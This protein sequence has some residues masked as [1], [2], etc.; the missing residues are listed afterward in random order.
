MNQMNRMNNLMM[1]NNNMMNLMMNQMNRMNNPMMQNNNMMNQMNRNNMMP[2]NN[3]MNITPMNGMNNPMMQNTPGMMN[4]N[5][6][7]QNNNMNPM[8]QNNNMNPMM[9]NSNMNPMM[10]QMMNMMKNNFKNNQM[11]N[12]YQ[13]SQPMPSSKQTINVR[14]KYNIR[15]LSNDINIECYPDET[16]GELIQKYRVKTGDNDRTKKFIYNAKK[17]DES[18][19]I[20]EAG[21]LDTANIFVVKTE[22][23][24]GA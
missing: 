16:V 18:L 5:P 15:N 20:S 11:N 24:M 4:R 6:M 9:P 22:G 17:L 2:N 12:V 7:M 21:I 3:M 14:F 13:P 8:M 19:K 1:Q 23:V 10:I